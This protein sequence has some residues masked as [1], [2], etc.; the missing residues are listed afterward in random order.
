MANDPDSIGPAAQNSVRAVLAHGPLRDLAG[1]RSDTARL[2]GVLLVRAIEERLTPSPEMM[3]LPGARLSVVVDP[4]LTDALN[5]LAQAASMS[6]EDAVSSL[7]EQAGRDH[8]ERTRQAEADA[9]VVRAAEQ[10]RLENQ[11]LEVAKRADEI[12]ASSIRPKVKTEEVSRRIR[13]FF[14]Y[15]EDAISIVKNLPGA[16]F[17]GPTRDDGKAYWHISI[18]YRSRVEEAIGRMEHAI[19]MQ[20]ATVEAEFAAENRPP[21]T[22]VKL[23]IAKGRLRVSFPFSPEGVEV[24]RLLKEKDLS[25]FSGGAWWSSWNNRQSIYQI[26]PELESALA[27]RL[28]EGRARGNG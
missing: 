12:L 3:P 5:R 9:A 25:W 7:I 4:N 20:W 8:L 2:A 16:A 10:V 15:N 21:A 1:S 11:A 24:M 13:L 19:A 28:G 26:I 14:P 23:G 17:H 18:R 27:D 6:L 22:R